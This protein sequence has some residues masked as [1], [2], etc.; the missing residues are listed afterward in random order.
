[1][2]K[3][4]IL[5]A[6]S[7]LM[8][9]HLVGAQA[10]SLDDGFNRI[11]QTKQGEETVTAIVYM[12]D[13]VDLEQLDNSLNNRR[14]NLRE[15]HEIVVT[16]LR[17]KAYQTQQSFLGYLESQRQ[18]G[19]VISYRSH[20]ISNIVI[21]EAKANF[22]KDMPARPD[23]DKI[24]YNYETENIKPE[25][26]TIPEPD[27]IQ[28]VEIGVEVIR[29]P[30]VWAL[31]ITGSGRLVANI[32]TGVDGNHPALHDRW[33]GHDPRYQDHPEWAWFDPYLGQNDFPYDNGGHGT[34]T[35][36]TVCGADPNTGDTVGV[37]P[38]AQ[39][40]AAGAIDRG[41]G[42]PR[43]VADA[44]A[45]F[46][47]MVDPDGNPATNWDV[48]DVCSNSWGVTTGHGYPPCDETF[49]EY[50]DA[51]EA[52]GI[53]IIFSAG[54]EGYS[55]LRRPADRA[56]TDLNA[57]AVGAIDP[58]TM[59]IASFSSRGPTY[60][61]P[62]GS[63]AIKPEIS[64]PGV[65]TR[66]C[67]PGG[68]YTTMS[69]TSMASPHINGV[70]ALMREANPNLG[71]DLIKEILLETCDD[72]GA[73][74]EDNDYGHGIVDAYD[75]VQRAIAL[76]EGYGLLVGRVTNEVTGGG[77]PALVEVTNRDMPTMARCNSEGYYQLYV[78]ADSLWLLEAS[79][80]PDFLPDFGQV[81]VAENETVTV[82]FEL[83]PKV[84][85]LFK[86]QFAN[87]GDVSYREFFVRG[88][89]DEDGFWR[90]EPS[91]EFV[92]LRDDGV[93][94]DEVEGDGIFTGSNKLATDLDHTYEWALFCEEHIEDNSAFMQFGASFTITDPGN[95]PDI[96]I[97]QVNPSGSDPNWGI[98]ARGTNGINIDLV[99]GVNS[100][101]YKWGAAI[102]LT[103]GETYRFILRVMHSDQPHYGVGGVGG[104]SIE[105]ACTFS[106]SYDIIFNDRDDSY[107]I[108][109][110]GT[111]GPP[112]YLSCA[113]GLD[114]HIPV[115][116]MPPGTVESTELIYDDGQLQN[117]YYYYAYDAIMATMFV[118][119]SY[120]C[121]IDSVLVRVLTE[122]D[123]YWPWPDQ[124]HDPVKI[125]VWV[126]NDG[127][128]QPDDS[129][130]Y[131]EA[132]VPDGIGEWIR[133]DVPDIDIPNGTN[134][135]V[136]MSNMEGGGEEGI[137]LDLNTDY[138]AHKWSRFQGSWGLES[139][140]E[141]DHMI[142][143]KVFINEGTN[144]MQ[145]EN[146]PTGNTLPENGL[147]LAQSG[148]RTSG[149]GAVM[150]G[151]S[152]SNGDGFPDL[153]IYFPKIVMPKNGFVG[154]DIQV[155]S[156]YNLYRST[157]SGPYGQ[158]LKI[159]DQLITETQYDDWGNDQYGPIANGQLYYYEATAVY[160]VGGGDYVEIGPSNEATGQAE[161]HPPAVPQNLAGDVSNHTVTLWWTPNTDY[162][163]D[164]YNI[165]R[166]D[167]NQ[168]EFN[169][170]GTVNHPDTT[171]SEYIAVDG[172]YR[173]KITAV[174]AE[175]AE[176][177]FSR[178]IDLPVGLIPPG[179]LQASDDEEFQISLRWRNP[180]GLPVRQDLKVAMCIADYDNAHQEVADTLLASGEAEEVDFIDCQNGTPSLD[181]LLEYDVVIAWTNYTFADPE[182][183]GNVLADYIDE[184]GAVVGCEFMYYDGWAVGGRYMTDYSPF[185]QANSGYV[186]VS[187]GEYDP[188]HPIMSDVEDVTEYFCH[189]VQAA[190]N[191]EVVASW[192][193]NW[194]FVAYNTDNPN[195][196]GINGY[197]GLPNRQWGGDMLT[198]VINSVVFVTSGGG[199]T[200]DG[201]RLYKADSES[202][203]FQL[204]DE[205]PGEQNDYVDFPVPNAVDYF[206]KVTALYDGDESDPSN[207]AVG[208][209]MN[210]APEAPTDLDNS[211]T[212]YNVD[213]TWEFTNNMGDLDYY[214]VYRKRG[215]DG[216][217]DIVGTST[218]ESF[219]DNIQ[220][221]EDDVYLYRVTAV[222]NG[223]PGL[224]G[225]PSNTSQANVGN[226]PPGN[227][228]GMS[229]LDGM[230]ELRWTEP[231]GLGMSTEIAYDDGEL[232]EAYYYYAYD[233]IMAMMFEPPAYPC[234][235]DSAIVH[236]LT[237]GD[238]YWPWPD[239][240]HDPVVISVWLDS[241]G[242]GSPDDSVYAVET[243]VPDGDG[244]WIRVDVP[245]IDVP[246]GTNFWI[247]MSN[248]AGGGEEGIGLDVATNFP[249][250]NW[251]RIDGQWG[252]ENSYEGDHMIRAMAFVAGVMDENSGEQTSI[253][254]APV[255]NQP[256]NRSASKAVAPVSM[257]TN[258]GTPGTTTVSFS[259]M[260]IQIPFD[261]TEML[262]YNLYRDTEPGVPVDPE[263]RVN[264]GYIPETYYEDTG[265]EN[266]TTYYYV[267]TAVYDNGSGPEE[268][269]P[270]NEISA[271]PMMPAMM[272]MEPGEFDVAVTAGEIH[273]ENL[274]ITNPGG[275]ELE[276]SLVP[277]MDNFLYSGGTTPEQG[278]NATGRFFENYEDK[279]AGPGPQGEPV[280]LDSGGP[281]DFGYTWIDSD[282][283]NGPVYNWVDIE[284]R[285]VPISMYDDDNQ[286]P[287]NL[288]FDF[289]FYDNTFGSIRICSNGFLS[290]TSTSTQ[291]SNY[292]IPDPN[293]PT[294]LIAPFWDDLNPSQG[295]MVYYWAG[296]DS[297]VVSW[298]NV[299]H[300]S[301]GGPYTFQAIITPDGKITYQYQDMNYP[302]NDATVGIQNA[303]GTIGLQVVYNAPYI[304]NDLAVQ[305]TLGWLSVEPRGGA[306]EPGGEMDV[307]VIFDASNLESG[308]YTGTIMCHGWDMN[309]NLDDVEIPVTLRVS[310]T[311]IGDDKPALPTV[312]RLAQNYPN[313]FNPVTQIRYDLPK[314]SKV[315]LEIF[316]IL[317]QRV[318]T[319]IDGMETAGYKTVVWD[320]M[321]DSGQRVTSGIYF[322]HLKAGKFEAVKK[323]TIVK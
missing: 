293:Q 164:R 128:G 210:Y 99:G 47:W 181:V 229:N 90:Q 277:T 199:I 62:D 89:W 119:P 153:D 144:A 171:F 296:D 162:D 252:I 166:R 285:G 275:L 56:T 123:P 25:A 98:S 85:V 48:P 109:L 191:A 221:G 133:V 34:H 278:A 280:T 182:A 197:L 213:L 67:Y 247:G 208:R 292:P 40:M 126:D 301:T 53:V 161:N 31:G 138:P 289:P 184:G 150:P 204:L 9:G 61:T 173:Y 167:Y 158:G 106:G 178:H 175:D 94:P 228:R 118:P 18:A 256:L 110:T 218:M 190:E 6:V 235:I 136:G 129:V 224:E 303:N 320:G 239:P 302:D 81:M 4:L 299:P 103:E 105:Y 1:M 127:N 63:E 55:G 88:T 234:I 5:L 168:S 86:A 245:D 265:L 207:T 227:L 23:I 202:G 50:L 71:V 244:E 297:F 30:E 51:C 66:S 108:Q 198:V 21:V 284:G 134:F 57:F 174:D 300:Y 222:D 20:W 75:A 165:Y 282:E 146:L 36:G 104:D 115:S 97:L 313:P 13:R 268:S 193:N 37:A 33:R 321:N 250:N 72:A 220:E 261:I 312:Y 257:G 46:E 259:G 65:N 7:A 131:A 16:A 12:A 195:V 255:G 266:G 10:A 140:Y 209:G 310:P 306:V 295:G 22:F 148:S 112:T 73:P 319:L 274:H 3:W 80:P 79:F 28:N 157:T 160:D 186:N 236:V 305:F 283:P 102:E 200:P 286:G 139:T 142:R 249:Q 152:A 270:S 212:G 54:N 233:A 231:G 223:D 26:S 322:Y 125:T 189:D 185:T 163:I 154:D 24:Y 70:V 92:V 78:P 43:T 147:S 217:F 124:T 288:G 309:H 203:P 151:L 87:P 116:W 41:G 114:G 2:K 287:F 290:F 273:H 8:L 241:D 74:G 143:A 19:N 145:Y 251:S 304:H 93:A 35:M 205:L 83:E 149:T 215:F 214:N 117:G 279:P 177:G 254:L 323:M 15:R 137:G 248:L 159:N 264:T 260:N 76:L 170:V 14:V 29:A 120:P 253:S 317:G 27:D 49:W 172:I 132:T 60:C 211:V 267:V 44:I 95:P 258:P 101:P 77:L 38:G 232:A 307:D 272:E 32:D 230:V 269:N 219:T 183:M 82:N 192:D 84:E 96:P 91:D 169:L 225:E 298:I 187:L 314:D 271:T 59:Q 206:Y 238:P 188:G 45:S 156:G 64:A 130:F 107:L 58:T 294:N 226:L 308:V 216:E 176:S 311:T 17:E 42:I 180:G 281:D 39:W 318:R 240:T 69:G 121:I 68:G 122:G 315:R 179:V 11:L 262:G 111:E 141:G 196:V 52:A 155:L 246:E 100:D 242:N 201:Y 276:F 263:H 291:Y 237:E 194:P 113:N 135:W 243:V 316:N